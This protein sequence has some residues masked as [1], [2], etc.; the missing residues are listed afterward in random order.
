MPDYQLGKIYK[1]T[2]KNTDKVYIG[3]TTHIYLRHRFGQ[4]KEKGEMN[5]GITS[6]EI[7]DCGD[8][9][10]E[11]I[12]YYPCNSKKELETR[13]S[14]WIKNTPNCVNKIVPVRTKEELKEMKKEWDKK[15]YEKNKEKRLEKMADYREENREKIRESDKVRRAENSDKFREKRKCKQ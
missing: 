9:D 10:I 4:H 12:E 13:E 11:L 3:S 2:S 7:I 5:K 15:S 6:A 1:I 8:C 14:H